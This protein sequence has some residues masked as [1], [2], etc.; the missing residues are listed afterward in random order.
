MK[1]LSKYD[2]IHHA[3]DR[4]KK[5][6]EGLQVMTNRARA[7]SQARKIRAG[8]EIHLSGQGS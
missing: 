6:K 3:A 5:N 4:F 7:D 2:Q 8:Q 1:L